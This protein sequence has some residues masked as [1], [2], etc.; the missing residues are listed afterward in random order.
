FKVGYKQ[1][2]IVTDINSIGSKISKAF[3]NFCSEYGR[4]LELWFEPGKFIVSE[5]GVLLVKANLIKQTTST[6]FVGVNS[7]QNHLI[8]PMFYQA[9]HEITN[10]SNLA[11]E[12]RLY[13]I[14]G[15]I[16]ESDTFGFDRML[17]EVREGDILA[18]SNAGAYGFSMSNQY[19]SRL[20]PAEVLILNEES[21][22]IRK[23]ETLEDLYRNEIEVI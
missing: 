22:L 16:C 11:G 3:R 8:R 9:Y 7:G 10:I 2:D 13:S 14:V 19:N 20:R 5:S 6:V 4:E 15:Y 18:I 23:R 12:Q 21:F 17:N 1:G